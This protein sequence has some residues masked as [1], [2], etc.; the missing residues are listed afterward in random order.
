MPRCSWRREDIR[1]NDMSDRYMQTLDRKLDHLEAETVK[2]EA[3][4]GMCVTASQMILKLGIATTVVVGGSL[5]VSGHLD[6]MTFLIFLV[7][8][9]RIFEPLSGALGNLAAIFNTMLQVGRSREIT[10]CPI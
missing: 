7:A 6:F 4:T 2:S 10:E 8:A 9:S 3:I 1:A 5:L